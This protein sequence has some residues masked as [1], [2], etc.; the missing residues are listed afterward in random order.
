MKVVHKVLTNNIS[1]C[2]KNGKA[3][4]N[5]KWNIALYMI[6]STLEVKM[7][8][9]ILAI[10]SSAL[11]SIMMRV[12]EAS[13][14]SITVLCFN[15]LTCSILSVIYNGG[16][17][18]SGEK[19]NVALILGILTGILYL[20]SLALLRVSIRKNGVVLSSTFMKLGVLVPIVIAIV[21]F[22]ERPGVLGIAGFILAI[23]SIIYIN[24]KGEEGGNLKGS[25][26]LFLILLGGGFADSLTNFYEKL[27]NP[28]LKDL[29]L[30]LTFFTAFIISLVV[31]FIKKEK[32]EVKDIIYGASIGIPNYYASRFVLLALGKMNATIVYPVYNVGAILLVTVFGVLVFK[33]SLNKRK[34]IGMILILISLILLN[35]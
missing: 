5:L 6:Y 16:F 35:I 28:D 15:Y 30:L 8:Y 18:F 31:R 29:Y 26:I 12:S 23:L 9:L 10:V 4:E 3:T 34:K 32:F 11:V 7:I 24:H 22:N 13:K 33:E 14:N 27:G 1:Y 25:Y 2:L 19:I 20:V 17:K 21:I